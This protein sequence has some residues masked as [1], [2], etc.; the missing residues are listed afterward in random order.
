[1][2]KLRI[3][4]T[5]YNTIRVWM[6]FDENIIHTIHQSREYQLLQLLSI[7]G[8]YDKRETGLYSWELSMSL[9]IYVKE[10]FSHYPNCEIML[11][12]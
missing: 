6:E 8:G 5:C 11:V 2:F 12:G 9:S 1:M 3:D 10:K 7:W 4:T